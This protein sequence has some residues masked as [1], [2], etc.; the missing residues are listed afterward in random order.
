MNSVGVGYTITNPNTGSSGYM[1]SGGIDSGALLMRALS[2]VS[3]WL[4]HF[5]E[6]SFYS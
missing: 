3:S 6:A 2:L 5:A 4:V 1:I